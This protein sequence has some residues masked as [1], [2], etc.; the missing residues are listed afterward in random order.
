MKIEMAC[1]KVGNKDGLL[2]MWKC[3]SLGW[4]QLVILI[5]MSAVPLPR[6]HQ[7]FFKLWVSFNLMQ[8]VKQLSYVERRMLDLVISHGFCVSY[9]NFVVLAIS[10]HKVARSNFW[11]LQWNLSFSRGTHC[12]RNSRPISK[13]P[14]LSKILEKTE[15][16]CG[17]FLHE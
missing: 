11:P 7:I 10:D 16:T 8:H 13:L 4:F 5:S 12:F 1:R 17:G 9:V 3:V 14:F 6:L 15:S 2:L